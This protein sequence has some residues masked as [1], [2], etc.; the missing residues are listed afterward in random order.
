[1]NLEKIQT[2]RPLAPANERSDAQVVLATVFVSAVYATVR[3]NVFKGV[4][5]SDWPHYIGNKILAVASLLLIALAVIRLASARRRPIR[6][7]MV[8]ASGMALA[9]TL[10]SLALLDPVYFEKF[11]S[12]PRLTAQAGASLLIGAAALAVLQWGK[13]KPGTADPARAAMTLGL[14]AF[15]SATHAA[16][17]STASW[18]DPFTWPGHMPPLTLV[19]FLAGAAALSA[20]MRVQRNFR[21][22]CGSSPAFS[23]PKER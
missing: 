13:G 9:H 11:Y 21:P 20:A 10:I 23:E 7:L 19:S 4:N 5:W 1:M 6:N 22:P 16:I 3:Y 18:F 2:N 8:W 17:P 12:G 15:L 14:L